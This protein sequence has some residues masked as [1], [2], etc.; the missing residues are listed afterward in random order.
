[1]SL[2]IEGNLCKDKNF[3]ILLAAFKHY[4]FIENLNASR[5]DL[6]DF[7]AQEFSQ[8]IV[9]N[10]KLKVLLANQNRFMGKGGSLIAQAVGKA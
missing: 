3:M 9:A 10:N 7:C 5:N 6:T 4:T 2:N 1:M 8:T